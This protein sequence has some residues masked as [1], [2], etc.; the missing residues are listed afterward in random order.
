MTVTAFHSRP[1][2]VR[3]NDARRGQPDR[4]AVPMKEPT[5]LTVTFEVTLSGASRFADAAEVLKALRQ[6]TDDLAVGSVDVEPAGPDADAP[7]MTATTPRETPSPSEPDHSD[8]IRVLPDSREVWQAGESL[9]LTRVEY[10]LLLFLALHPRRVFTR[11]QLL[12][13]VWGFAHA[14]HRTVDV[15]I[16]R[17]RAK[18]GDNLVTTVRGVGYRLAD[19][20]TVRVLSR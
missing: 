1:T 18:L 2:R 6:V 20:A 14:G 19:E 3:P 4:R 8:L 9:A 17:L 11:S 12:Q 13:S 10:D 15:H 16:R 7:V 5:A